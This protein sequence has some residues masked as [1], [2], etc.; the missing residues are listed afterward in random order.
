MP[1]IH[2]VPFDEAEG[3]LRAEYEA[4]IKRAGK[5]FNV[6]SIQS[7]SPRVLRAS[8][9]LYTALMMAQGALPRWTRELLATVVSHANG[10]HY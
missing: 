3:S 10:C 7:L 5:V 9:G 4:A 6:V 2:V 8:I 1:H